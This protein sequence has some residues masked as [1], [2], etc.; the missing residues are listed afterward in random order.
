[1]ESLLPRRRRCVLMPTSDRARI[2]PSGRTWHATRLVA[3]RPILAVLAATAVGVGLAH[4]QDSGQ[5]HDKPG[6]SPS[7][8][9]ALLRK[10]EQM[11]ERIRALENQLRQK[12]ARDIGRARGRAPAS[13]ADGQPA[14]DQQDGAKN[15]ARQSKEQNRA[16]DA[17]PPDWATP[18]ARDI[19]GKAGPTNAPNSII[20]LTQSPVTG[21]RTQ[22]PM[23]NGRTASTPGV[24]FCCRPT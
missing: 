9:P 7:A 23:A 5:G 16:A 1:V 3:L 15:E 19:T 2:A 8:D 20:G 22:L 18:A 6:S 10:L 14:K 21:L 4:A 17:A 12:D 24:W 13:P 11:E